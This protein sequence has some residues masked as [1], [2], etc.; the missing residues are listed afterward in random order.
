MPA[1]AASILVFLSSAAVL[2]LELLAARLLIPYVGNTIETYTAIIGV[3]LAGIALGTWLGGRA[4][5]RTA[6]VRLLAPLLVVGGALAAVTVPIVDGLGAGL[7]GAGPATTTILTTLAF[8]VPAAVLSAITPVVIK[9]QLSSLDHTGRVV[10]RLSALSTLGGI[11][12]TFLTGFVLVALFPTRTTI[13]VVA[14]LLVLGG[15]IVALGLGRRSPVRAV[16]RL[17]ADG[18]MPLLGV[19]PIAVALLAGA[20]SFATSGPCDQ[21]SA[22]YCLAVRQDPDRPDGRFLWLDTLPH[23]HV[24][25]ADPTV[26]AFTYTAWYGDALQGT[27]ATPRPLRALHIGAGGMTMPRWLRALHPASS[28]VVLELDPRVVELAS[29]DLGFI[30]GPD[31]TVITGD[32]RLGVRE[33]LRLHGDDRAFEVIIGD[34]FG[35]IAV[36]WH[37]TTQEFTSDLAALLADDGIYLLN[38]IDHEE[39]GLLR[40]ELATIAAVLPHVAVLARADDQGGNHVVIASRAPLALTEIEAVNRRR[41]RTDR[42]I[43]GAELAVLIGDAR[44]LTDDRAPVDQLLT[45]RPR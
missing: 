25:L 3:V 30:P 7:R 17:G 10:G 21:E 27:F 29:S 13:R 32:A 23:S 33:L 6:P 24:D 37:L 18:S 9:L 12:G 40:A 14:G 35:G 16:G 20:A 11:A 5:D 34:A 41:G 1:A 2:V 31:V 22:Y 45:A 26:L 28:Q 43:H 39:R 44:V 19:A 8:L 36:P 4:A 15:A 42:L 38:I